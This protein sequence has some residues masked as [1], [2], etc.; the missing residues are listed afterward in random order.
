MLQWSLPLNSM[1]SAKMN[2]SDCS[3]KDCHSNTCFGP[4]VKELIISVFCHCYSELGCEEFDVDPVS[5]T[6]GF[7]SL[8]TRKTD[9]ILKTIRD[10]SPLSR[11]IENRC[12]ENLNNAFYLRNHLLGKSIGEITMRKILAIGAIGLLAVAALAL[13][14]RKRN[15]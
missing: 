10:P 6:L 4:T 1:Y 3:Y 2:L 7:E 13:F 11:T 14:V 12:I 5:I 9:I 8:R 15:R